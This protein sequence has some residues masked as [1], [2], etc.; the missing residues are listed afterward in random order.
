MSILLIQVHVFINLLL[1]RLVREITYHEFRRLHSKRITP[2][3]ISDKEYNKGTYVA[4]PVRW[5]IS[6]LEALH[7][8]SEAYLVDLLKDAHLLAIHARRINLQPRDIQLA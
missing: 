5:Q 6:A 2:P 1:S 7:E 4:C 8:A 3:V